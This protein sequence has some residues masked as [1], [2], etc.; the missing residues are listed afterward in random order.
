MSAICALQTKD[1][2]Y[3]PP[4]KPPAVTGFSGQ[5][6]GDDPAYAW[7]YDGVTRFER[8]VL[9]APPDDWEGLECAEMRWIRYVETAIMDCY[10][11]LADDPPLPP[12]TFSEDEFFDFLEDSTEL[13]RY[14]E[15]IEILDRV[16][17][18]LRK[19]MFVLKALS[20]S[21]DIVDE[22]GIEPA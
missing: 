8:I 17:I 13:R 1:S 22:S 5:S 12:P 19:R 15:L 10:L 4:N 6:G 7:L 11:M 2:G 3:R 9:A 18:L 21:S 14:K 16:Q 20:V